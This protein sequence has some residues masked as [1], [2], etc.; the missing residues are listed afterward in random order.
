M[1]TRYKYRVNAT[2]EIGG[3]LREDEIHFAIVG[4]VG[5]KKF[6]MQLRC[7]DGRD[8]VKI[9]LSDEQVVALAEFYDY[10]CEKIK[11][12]RDFFQHFVRN[13]KF[14]VSGL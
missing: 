8:A 11:R 3:E 6:F 5:R 9:P 1:E 2:G 12:G 4:D 7:S 14:E 10:K 13:Y